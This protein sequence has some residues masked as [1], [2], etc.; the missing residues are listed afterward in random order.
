[1]LCYNKIMATPISP[2]TSVYLIKCPLEMDNEHQLNFANKQ[3]QLNYFLSLP[4]IELEKFSYQ[5]QDGVIR[6]E[7]HIDDIIGYNYVIYQNENYTNRWFFA[8]ITGMEYVNDNCTY[9]SIKTDVF[10]TWY[11]DLHFNQCFVEREHVNDDTFGL[12]T[13]EENI[14]SGEWFNNGTQQVSMDDPKDCF[15]VVML[16]ELIGGLYDNYHNYARLYCGIPN[17]CFIYMIDI[18]EQSAGAGA[19]N[20]ID[21]LIKYYDSKGK[22]DAIT[23][24]YLVPRSIMGTEGTDYTQLDVVLNP[25]PEAG[26]LTVSGFVPAPSTGVKLVKTENVTMNT[27]LNGYTPKNNKCFTKQFNYLMLINNA[28]ASTTYNWED[29]NGTPNFKL[30][31]T[32]QQTAPSKIVPTNYKGNDEPSGNAYALS[33]ATFPIVS[34]NSDYYLNY[35]A[36][37]GWGAYYNRA[38]NAGRIMNEGK[39]TGDYDGFSWVKEIGFGVTQGMSAIWN[40][41]SG[42]MAQAET[43]PNTV[44]GDPTSNDFTFSINKCKFTFYK[45]SM[46]AEV[47]RVVDK[48]FSAYGYKVSTWKLPNLNGRQNWNYIKLSQANITAD[49]PQ[50]DLSE[51]KSMFLNGIT[52]WHNPN[53]F[54]DYSQNNG[55]VN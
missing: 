29:F 2:N 22:A 23:A 50:E 14:P 4:K 41:I 45:M 18:N 35:Q 11:F 28:G 10:N 3:S 20:S 5:R 44:G 37:Q 27:T 46:R 17:G 43:V 21:N 54:Q 12:H 39:R 52:I 15:V 31:A 32:F 33:G 53:T 24:M 51:I 49:I 19:Y 6:V 42:S 40:T 26:D 9:V 25:A 47:A 13:L 55:I 16:S 8:Y 1:M 38:M 30:F 7:N 34:W 48:Y 36:K